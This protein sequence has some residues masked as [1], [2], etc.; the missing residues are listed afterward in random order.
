VATKSD[1]DT[2]DETLI[3]S[4][5]ELTVGKPYWEVELL[6][7]G[8]SLYFRD[9]ELLNES[10]PYIGVTRPNLDHNDNL[11]PHWQDPRWLYDRAA[12]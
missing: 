6:N 3:T 1:D 8:R 2:Y 4:G 5:V 12:M 11:D 10:D 7:D 9:Q